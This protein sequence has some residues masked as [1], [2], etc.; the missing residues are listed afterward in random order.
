MFF[1]IQLIETKTGDD[2]NP[3]A[4]SWGVVSGHDDQASAEAAVM[5]VAKSA[6]GSFFI[7]QAVSTVKRE[8]KIEAFA[9]GDISVAKP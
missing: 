3:I 8:P 1:V 6:P 5:S 9:A 2:E 4:Q 7:A